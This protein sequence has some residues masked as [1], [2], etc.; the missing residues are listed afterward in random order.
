MSR[1]RFIYP[2]IFSS[3]DFLSLSHGA[4]LMFIGMFTIAD[5]YGRGKG[6]LSTL[7]A[8]IFG[9]DKLARSRVE[10]WAEEIRDRGMA[11]WY[12][13]GASTYY[14]LPSWGRWQK[15]KYKADPKIPPFQSNSESGPNPGQSG[16]ESGPNPAT[17]SNWVGLGS[18]REGLEKASCAP[19][20]ARAL[21]FARFWAAYPSRNGAK[22]GRSRAESE[23]AK[24]KLE[25]RA[26]ELIDAITRQKTHREECEKAGA[27]CAEFQDAERWIRN[28]RWDDEIGTVSL[29][30]KDRKEA[31]RLA[32]I[33]AFANGGDQ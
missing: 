33:E 21:G 11:R 4:R 3:E 25:S 30:T 24:A 19:R 13:I 1:Q 18:G 6:A 32:G 20:T 22:R 5:D 16:P 10:S 27:F 17:G 29:S 15:P 8:S 31:E 26:D 28:R 7:Q 12:T 9:G 23:W 2:E 14:D